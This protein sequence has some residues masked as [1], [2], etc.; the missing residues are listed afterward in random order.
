MHSLSHLGPRIIFGPAGAE[1]L[2]SGGKF[3][4]LNFFI[5]ETVVFAWI[6]TIVLII[7]ALVL[8]RKMEK[9]PKGPQII[10][11]LFVEKIYG[12][13]ENTMG[14]ACLPYAPYIGTLICFL[15]L[16]NM[17]GLFGV[18]PVTSDLNATLALALITFG[19]I[20]VGSFRAR[21]PLGYIKHFGE[22]IPIMYPI[23]I[24]ED[25]ALPIS[26]ACRLFGNI[27]AGYIIMALIFNTLH[28][29]CANMGSSVP[30]LQILI[31]IVPNL[32]FDVFEPVLQ[33]YIFIMLTMIFT[34][35]AVTTHH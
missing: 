1:S 25:V 18:R 20:Q 23:K 9:V 4:N 17:L 7:L 11:E 28:G 10:A 12:M 14:K 35:N 26:L 15:V 32:F 5:T 30:F 2:S 16:S 31:P 22:P 33:G 13:V 6:V 24:I 3:L 19:I 8:T 27:L 21:G 29:V 34:K